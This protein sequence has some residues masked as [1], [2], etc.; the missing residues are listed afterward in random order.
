[1]TKPKP[2]GKTIADLQAA[3]DK[4]VIIPNRIRAALDALLSSDD[5]WA[6]EIDFMKLS[7]PPLGSQDIS[8]YREQFAEYWA[9]MPSVNGKSQIRRVWFATTDAKK[10]WENSI[11][12]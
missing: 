6:Y 4:N 2:K 10:E 9:E 3:H 5:A 1:M 8:K 11:N 7:K 12:G